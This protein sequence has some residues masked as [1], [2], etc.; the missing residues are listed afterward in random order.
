MSQKKKNIQNQSDQQHI[1]FDLTWPLNGFLT[2]LLLTTFCGIAIKEY[3]RSD[4]QLEQEKIKYEKFLDSVDTQK[5]DTTILIHGFTQQN[6][7]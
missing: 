2:L 4:M 5:S 6:V 3:K 7:R 1:K